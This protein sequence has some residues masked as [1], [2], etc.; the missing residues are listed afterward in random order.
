MSHKTKLGGTEALANEYDDSYIITS[1]DELLQLADKTS[2]HDNDNLFTVE[3]CLDKCTPAT[4]ICITDVALNREYVECGIM[5]DG[6]II[7]LSFDNGKVTKFLDSYVEEDATA[8]RNNCTYTLLLS[9]DK[10]QNLIIQ[11]SASKGTWDIV[12][13][14]Q[15]DDIL[16]EKKRFYNFCHLLMYVSI[17]LFSVHFFWYFHL[18]FNSLLNHLLHFQF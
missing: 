1:L 12:L 17:L 6:N 5:T 10:I 7:S 3:I 18:I 13:T 15:M 11:K 14:Q 9:S 2:A 8:I 16:K 4:I